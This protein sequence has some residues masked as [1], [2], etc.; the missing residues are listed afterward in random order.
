MTVLTPKNHAASK[1]EPSV[2]LEGSRDHRLERVSADA[3]VIDQ[4]PQ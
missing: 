3:R 2:T 1:I 4:S